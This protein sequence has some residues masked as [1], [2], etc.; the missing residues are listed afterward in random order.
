MNAEV[1]T[2]DGLP[3]SA[4]GAH[5]LR[6]KRP[7]TAYRR[8]EEFTAACT[9][10]L[11]TPELSFRLWAGGEAGITERL[12]S[13]AAERLGGPRRRERMRTE[14]GVPPEAVE[15]VL[16][17]LGSAGARAVTP[18][19]HPLAGLVWNAR[20]AL[21]DASTTSP[22]DGL[23]AEA[24]GRFAVDG[25]GRV[26][27]DSG[28]RATI[29]TTASSLSLWLSLPGDDRLGPAAAHL[30]QHLPFRLSAK[31]WRR[32]RPTLDGSA[33]RSTRIAS[34]LAG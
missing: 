22:Y 6:T 9:R 5:S 16:L 7:D 14:W 34:P 21:T 4:G 17:A 19:G 3:A 32:W 20:V 10:A 25:Y 23:D 26:L 1:V 18:H 31:H 15:D 8:V 2:Y 30:Q 29:G 11:E 12:T 27:G 13:F 33:Y 24:F 28:V